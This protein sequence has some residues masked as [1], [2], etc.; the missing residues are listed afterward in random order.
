MLAEKDHRV[1]PTNWNYVSYNTLMEGQTATI[2]ISL[3]LENLDGSP[4]DFD[5]TVGL[6]GRTDRALANEKNQITNGFMAPESIGGDDI[7][8]WFL[9]P[10]NACGTFR[11]S[12][13]P[14]T[15]ACS[16]R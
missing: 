16:Q 13:S 3:Y 9:F 5:G 8:G 15:L 6:S 14:G 2:G 4:L 10:D 7:I 12:P 11:T 1:E